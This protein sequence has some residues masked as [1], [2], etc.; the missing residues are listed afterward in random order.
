MSIRHQRHWLIYRLHHI[1]LLPIIRII[2]IL[3]SWQFGPIIHQIACIVVTT[4]A[5]DIHELIIIF[6]F[7]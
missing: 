1:S 3:L 5:A 4:I 6:I 7:L 2:R